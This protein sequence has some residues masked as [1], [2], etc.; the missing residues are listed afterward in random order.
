M[1]GCLYC[2]SEVPYPPKQDAVQLV[3]GCKTIY[4]E[5][6][7]HR[8]RVRVRF[9]FRVRVRVGFRVSVRF[10]PAAAPESGLR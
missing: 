3:I 7:E 5:A 2:I 4:S 6:C 9:R 1:H 10:M 8:V